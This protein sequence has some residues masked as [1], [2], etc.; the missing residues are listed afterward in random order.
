MNSGQ[1]NLSRRDVIRFGVAVGVGVVARRVPLH[2]QQVPQSTLITR[3]IP[4]T[5]E[6]IP[7]IGLGT[8]NYSAQTAEEMAARRAVLRRMPELGGSVVDTAANYGRSEEV[9]G[10]FIKE[11]GNRDRYFM[12]RR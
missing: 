7:V 6:R 2:A 9:I 12:P 1:D 10:A 3:P 4:S 5:G 11:L 8:N